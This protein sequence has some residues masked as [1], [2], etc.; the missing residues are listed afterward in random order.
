MRHA[1]AEKGPDDHARRLTPR[2][3]EQ[4]RGA[5]LWLQAKGIIPDVIFASDAQR[6]RQTAE[7]FSAKT[8]LTRAL[9]L[10]EADILLK[11]AEDALATCGTVMIIAH[12]PGIYEAALRLSGARGEDIQGMPPSTIVVYKNGL[13]DSVFIA[14]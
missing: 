12:N 3:M 9:Y 6:T 7:V 4:A 11:S 5:G 13:H 1:E 14:D 10:A 8:E 2:G